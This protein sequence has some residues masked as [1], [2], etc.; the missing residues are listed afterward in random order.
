LFC[1]RPRHTIVSQGFAEEDAVQLDNQLKQ[2]LKELGHA[3]NET[4]SDSERIAEAIANLR[5]AGFDIVLKL[6]AT[7]GLARRDNKPLRLT[8][9]DKRF[10]EALHIRVD[11]EIV[12]DEAT[13]PDVEMTAQDIRFLKSLKITLD[14][15]L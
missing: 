7:I 9:T 15:T 12:E 1:W 4:V 5:A 13:L 11:D 3:I 6:D 10:L 2:L 8:T 14:G